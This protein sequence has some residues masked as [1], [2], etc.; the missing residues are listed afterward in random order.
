MEIV[1][2][3]PGVSQVRM[4]DK[5]DH[6]ATLAEYRRYHVETRLSQ[7]C[8]YATLHCQ[9][10]RFATGCTEILYL[11]ITAAKLMKDMIKNRYVKEKLRNIV[12]SKPGVSQV[13]MYDKQDHMATLAEYRR[14]HHVETRL[15][16]SCIYATLHCQLCRFAT[17][18]TEILYFQITA[19]KLMKDM[20]K[21]RYVKE[22]F[23]NTLCII[24]LHDF[25]TKCFLRKI[26]D[27]RKHQGRKQA[28]SI[29]IGVR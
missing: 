21:N 26:T 15:S 18:C 1:Q 6:T 8:T 27:H 2:S 13:R 28:V 7:S 14:Y 12:Q 25:K 24:K 23:R 9:L 17:R 4:Y 5:Q 20:I 3:K 16:Q 29:C 10:C 11:Q 19:A 22:K